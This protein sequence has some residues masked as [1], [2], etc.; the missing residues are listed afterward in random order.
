MV[1]KGVAYLGVHIF[2]A[3]LN[4]CLDVGVI[5]SSYGCMVH[6]LAMALNEILHI[7]P[8]AYVIYGLS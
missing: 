5:S 4:K 7:S 6:F 1:M 8:P 2:R 3:Q